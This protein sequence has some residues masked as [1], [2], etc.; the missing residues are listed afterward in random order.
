M[1]TL[2]CSVSNCASNC[3]GG[4]CRPSVQI[5]APQ[6]GQEAQDTCCNSFAPKLPGTPSNS[7]AG[8]SPNAA[9]DI[10]CSASA[11]VHNQSG[12]CASGCVCINNGTSGTQCS[13]FEAR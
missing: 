7:A 12:S 4:C 3:S 5:N 11:C 8:L 13:T 10:R 9:L 1:T 6:S 2:K